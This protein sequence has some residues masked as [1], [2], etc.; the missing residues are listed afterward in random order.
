VICVRIKTPTTVDI[1]IEACVSSLLILDVY[2]FVN[3]KY[4]V[5]YMLLIEV[6]PNQYLVYE[7]ARL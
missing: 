4:V 3:C 6:L 5:L 2:M 1:I 7:A